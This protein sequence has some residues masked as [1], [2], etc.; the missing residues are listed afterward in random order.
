MSVEQR[1]A[2]MRERSEKATAGPWFVTADG[3]VCTKADGLGLLVIAEP[4]SMDKDVGDDEFIAH[5]RTD[6][7]DLRGAVEDVLALHQETRQWGDREHREIALCASDG[8]DW[9]C[10]TVA[11]ITARLGGA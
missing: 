1:L 7:D 6:L 10:P 8:E 9:P 3:F 5:A 4:Y 2:A 11:A